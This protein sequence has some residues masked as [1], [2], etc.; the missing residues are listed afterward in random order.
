MPRPV[1]GLDLCICL[2]DRFVIGAGLV[3]CGLQSGKRL[4]LPGNTGLQPPPYN[5]AIA[6][7][8][9]QITLVPRTAG[10]PYSKLPMISGVMMGYILCNAIHEKMA[11]G[12]VKHNLH[13]HAGAGAELTRQR[14]APAFPPNAASGC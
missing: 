10:I 2:G 11:D 4:H 3:D 14:K 6:V 7:A 8:Q 1:T 12:L 9:D 13:R 5:A